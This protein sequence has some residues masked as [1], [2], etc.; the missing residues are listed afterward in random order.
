MQACHRDK[1]RFNILDGKSSVV[2]SSSLLPGL[3]SK[4]CEG[5]GGLPSV[6]THLNAKNAFLRSSLSFFTL[7]SCASSISQTLFS[8]YGLIIS[9]P[10][11]FY[12]LP[13]LSLSL[14][15]HPTIQF[16]PCFATSLSSSLSH[17]CISSSCAQSRSP[18][19]V[20]KWKSPP[21]PSLD[22]FAFP[23][24]SIDRDFKWRTAHR[25]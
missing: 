23:Q 11:L 3:E 21:S 9:F 12:C 19:L 7:I 13:C 18:I 20:W 10:R 15:F 14:T 4:C 25:K 2:W 8:F 16:L 5:K 22:T 6:V 24:H 1:M 17:S